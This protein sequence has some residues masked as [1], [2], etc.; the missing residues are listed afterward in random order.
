MYTRFECTKLMVSDWYIVLYSYS[1]TSG[2]FYN[3]NASILVLSQ[4]KIFTELDLIAQVLPN[5]VFSICVGLPLLKKYH[6]K[7]YLI[8][9]THVLNQIRLARIVN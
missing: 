5:H 1:D 8:T 6:N 3:N 4:T 2:L 7:I 9:S